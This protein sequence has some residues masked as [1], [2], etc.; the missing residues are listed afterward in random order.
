MNQISKQL[1][2]SHKQVQNGQSKCYGFASDGKMYVRCPLNQEN[3]P[4]YTIR[5]DGGSV[6]VCR[7]FST[8]GMGPLFH[9]KRT[10]NVKMYKTIL[11]MSWWLRLMKA[12]PCTS[13]SFIHACTLHYWNHASTLWNLCPWDAEQCWKI[14]DFQQNITLRLIWLASSFQVTV[15]L[16]FCNNHTHTVYRIWKDNFWFGTC[17]FPA[18]TGRDA[19]RESIIIHRSFHHL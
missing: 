8:W 15:C 16:S 18:V 19:L 10:M 14:G 9:I 13:R 6:M 1:G 5:H 12:C 3:N 2:V 11:K 7:C 17:Q 4:K